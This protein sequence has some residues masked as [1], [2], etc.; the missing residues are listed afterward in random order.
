M[1]SN[2]IND[3]ET[4]EIVAEKFYGSVRYHWLVIIAN[5]IVDVKREW[6]L[7][8]RALV[9]YV[10]DKYGLNNRTDVHHYVMK[11]DTSVVVDWDSVLVAS[12]D[13]LAVT[14]LEHETDLN[15]KK[16]QILL[17]DKIFLKDITAQYL[18]LVK[19]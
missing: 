19:K 9:A 16:R 14:N 4:P 2:Y 6:P 3:G 18:R 8:Q 10:D 13:Y 15:D 17:L 1:Q 7:S 11:E 12:G 5:S